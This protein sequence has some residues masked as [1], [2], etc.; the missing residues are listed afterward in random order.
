VGANNDLNGTTTLDAQGVPP[1]SFIGANG[2]T[3]L[4]ATV[5]DDYLNNARD[6]TPSMGGYEVLSN[7]ITTTPFGPQTL[8]RCTPFT[9]TFTTTG[10][11][12]AGNIFTAQLSDASGSFAAPLAIGSASNTS[13]TPITC[14][15]PGTTAAGTKY[16]IRVTASNPSTIGTDN[17][18]D[19]TLAGDGGTGTWTWQGGSGTDWFDRCNWDKKTLPDASSDVSI[20][21]T[22]NKPTITGANANCN[23]IS[24]DSGSGAVLTIDATGGWKLNITQ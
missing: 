11:F 3:N 22:A 6:A 17:G 23:T 10:T 21:N 13:A 8:L 7:T 1:V 19:L 14:I 24:I 18:S 4:S 12:N 20:P 9:V 2:G 15:I 16:R 5:P